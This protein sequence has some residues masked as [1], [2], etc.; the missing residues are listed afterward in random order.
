[1]VSRLGGGGS[2]PMGLYDVP[3]YVPYSGSFRGETIHLFAIPL[4]SL[5]FPSPQ[6]CLWIRWWLGEGRRRRRRRACWMEGEKPKKEEREIY[7]PFPLFLSLFCLTA[8]PC[9]RI[10]RET[11]N[12][13]IEQNSRVRIFVEYLT[14]LGGVVK[15]EEDCL[16][17]LELF[18]PPP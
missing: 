11:L 7:A 15:E 17:K 9:L 1:M 5:L 8:Q 2:P 12:F 18:L 6:T 16:H 14:L 10:R 4:S 3:Q 13:A